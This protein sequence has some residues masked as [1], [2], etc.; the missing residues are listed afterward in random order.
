MGGQ[1]TSCRQ[2]VQLTMEKIIFSERVFKVWHFH[3][4]HSQLLIRAPKCHSFE[5]NIDLIFYGVDYM[6]IPAVF[7]GLEVARIQ[8]SEIRSLPA[9]AI[10]NSGPSWVYRLAT[11]RREFYVVAAHC[12]IHENELDFMESSLQTVGAGLGM[13]HSQK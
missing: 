13:E 12:R 5:K 4:T 7:N 8:D 11:E 6:G 10:T 2:P 9:V 1:R 3:V